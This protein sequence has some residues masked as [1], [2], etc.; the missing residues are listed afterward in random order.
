MRRRTDTLVCAGARATRD[1]KPSQPGGFGRSTDKSV[2]ATSTLGFRRQVRDTRGEAVL[3]A[4]LRCPSRGQRCKP[5]GLDVHRLDCRDIPPAMAVHRAD[6]R[7]TPCGRRCTSRGLHGLSGRSARSIAR[8]AR[9]IP[10]ARMASR[11]SYASSHS[12]FPR[13]PD[14]AHDRPS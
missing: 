8:Y 6:C 2:C 14:S 7:G 9:S 10:T 1:R 11:A 12:V 5:R 4:S 3:A 13:T